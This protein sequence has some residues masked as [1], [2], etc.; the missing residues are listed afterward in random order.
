[1]W[2]LPLGSWFREQGTLCRWYHLVGSSF[3]SR[4][5]CLLRNADLLYPIPSPDLLAPFCSMQT[6]TLSAMTHERHYV[7]SMIQ[8]TAI[9][10]PVSQFSL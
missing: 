4:V 1:M 8:A 7:S 5:S 6:S 10:R 3:S 9:Y 2:P